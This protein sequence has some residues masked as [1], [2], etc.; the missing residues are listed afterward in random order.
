ML[1]NLTEKDKTY[2]KKIGYIESDF[3]QIIAASKSCVITCNNRKSSIQSAIKNLGREIVLGALGR[4]SFHWT[5]ARNNDDN[6]KH[7]Y[8]D[9]SSY[10]GY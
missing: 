7:Y 8:F 9:C 2:L 6:T 5:C 3:E 1:F 10:F 4:A